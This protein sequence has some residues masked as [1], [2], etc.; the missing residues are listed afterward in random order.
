MKSLSALKHYLWFWATIA[1]VFFVY[2]NWYLYQPQGAEV[3][4]PPVD[5]WWELWHPAWFSWPQAIVMLLPAFTINLDVARRFG[6][7]SDVGKAVLF[8]TLGVV[9]WAGIGN[10]I[11]F[12]YQIRGE[13]APFPG[14]PDLGYIGLLP[15]YL[16]G[17]YHL[18]RV[19]AIGSQDLLRMIWVPIG[20]TFV[21]YMLT[22]PTGGIGGE[23][24]LGS[25]G[26]LRGDRVAQ[27]SVAYILVDLGLLPF[28]VMML[29]TAR[30][31]VGG[32]FF[33]PMAAV[34]ASLFCHV[35]ADLLFFQ[36]IAAGTYY[37]GDIAS[38]FYAGSMF[39]MVYAVYRF[40]RV[41][42]RMSGIRARAVPA[43]SAPPV[44]NPTP[45]GV[46]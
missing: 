38:C 25:W 19:L 43:A 3:A 20:A 1:F 21:V 14:L 9:S 40:G 5:H 10:L 45:G 12:S 17:L 8:L 46:S 42:E 15:M 23:W 28:A 7:H 30:R 22:L 26:D 32:L 31:L 11:F 39:L 35:A 41:H 4:A 34:V 33:D 16:I 44:A 2:L 29:L 27:T 13:V 36:R 24:V 6:L 37:T 18:S